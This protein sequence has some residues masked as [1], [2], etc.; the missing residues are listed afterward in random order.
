M[1][2][3]ALRHAT[4]E[5]LLKVPE[6]LVAES[7]DGELYTSPRPASRHARAASKLLGQLSMRFDDGEGGPGGW[8]IV[9]EPELHLGHQ[10][11]VPDIAGWRRENMPVYPD[12]AYFDVAPNWVCEVLSPSTARIDRMKKLP[13]YAEHGVQHV[14]IV[15][16]LDQMIEVYR[17]EN[18]RWIVA[19]NYG[20]DGVVRIEPFEA[21]ELALS[22]LWIEPA[23]K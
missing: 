23:A 8:W 13:L 12:S 14:W 11:L 20:G 5:D 19:G 7:I 6:N 16:P 2:E 3:L 1:T 21:V 22:G 18:G 15:N 10:V 9:V 17:L 4:Y